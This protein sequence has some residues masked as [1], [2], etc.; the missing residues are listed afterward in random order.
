MPTEAEKKAIKKYRAK[1]R[2]VTAIDWAI[3]DYKEVAQYCEDV[4]LTFGSFAKDCILSC[5]RAGYQGEKIDEISVSP[6]D[7][8]LP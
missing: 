1:S 4:G 2:K 7:P 6:R 8:D 3:S 5:V